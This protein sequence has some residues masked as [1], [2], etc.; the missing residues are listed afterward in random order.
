MLT[1]VVLVSLVVPVAT[2]AIVAAVRAAGRWP[3][4]HTREDR[5]QRVMRSPHH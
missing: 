5:I 2:A 3:Q 4:A 1:V